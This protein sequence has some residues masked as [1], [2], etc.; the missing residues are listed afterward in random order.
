VIAAVFAP[1][2]AFAAGGDNDPFVLYAWKN[3]VH[4]GI[5]QSVDGRSPV[6][7][8]VIAHKHAANFDGGVKAAGLFM[9]R[10][11]AMKLKSSPEP[12]PMSKTREPS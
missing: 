6:L 10:G 8:V 11:Y 9:I 4:V 2:G 3:L 7:A 1:I 12:Q 5:G